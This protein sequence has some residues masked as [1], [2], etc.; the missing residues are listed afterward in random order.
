MKSAKMPN[1]ATI[2]LPLAVYVNENEK[3]KI[4]QFFLVRPKLKK[5]ET[6][7][8]WIIRAISTEEAIQSGNT[9]LDSKQFKSKTVEEVTNNEIRSESKQD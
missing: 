5:G 3:Q 6:V 7:K 8:E 4:D 9:Q 1:K 2:R